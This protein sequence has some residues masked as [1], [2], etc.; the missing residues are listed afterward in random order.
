MDGAYT[1][2]LVIKDKDGNI[3]CTLVFNSNGQLTSIAFNAPARG[4][5]PQKTQ[6]AGFIFTVTGLNSGSTYSY[7]MTA[8]N[9]GGD[10]LKVEEGSFTTKAP[11]GIEDIHVDTS[12][13]IKV[14]ND[15]QIYILRG[16]KTYTITG[17]EV[18]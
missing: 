1:Y 4:D 11:Q 7:S 16:D 12:K 13:D 8:K 5:A 6:T 17:Q 2:E 18:R 9:E 3:V 14:L 15:G 10:A